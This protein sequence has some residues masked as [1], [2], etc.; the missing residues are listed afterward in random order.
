MDESVEVES[1]EPTDTMN[2]TPAVSPI[3]KKEDEEDTLDKSVPVEKEGT[4]GGYQ[5]PSNG[6]PQFQYFERPK[7]EEKGN[8]DEDEKTGLTTGKKK[9]GCCSIL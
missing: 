7:D 2:E 9:G 8:E 4:E 5:Q 6:A 3:K 1:K